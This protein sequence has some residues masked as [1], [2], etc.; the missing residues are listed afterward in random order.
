MSQDCHNWRQQLRSD[1]N[2]IGEL[3]HRLQEIAAKNPPK[4]LLT[5]VEHYHNQFYIQ[6]INIHDLKHA[7]KDY[8]HNLSG[9][10][11][12][13]ELVGKH[14]HLHQEYQNLEH[15]ISDLRTDFNIFLSRSS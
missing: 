7:I 14:D 8:E 12:S 13:D 15:I 2:E 10:D 9:Q 3:K 6:L 11:V 5:D 1:R 4:D